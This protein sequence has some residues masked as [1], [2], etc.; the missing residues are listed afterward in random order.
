MLIHDR[1]LFDA[2]WGTPRTTQHGDIFGIFWYI[3]FDR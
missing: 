1:Y 3:M 2:S